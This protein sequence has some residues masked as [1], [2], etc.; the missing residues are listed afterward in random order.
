MLGANTSRRNNISLNHL[1]QLE[2][3][4]RRSLIYR[5]MS[6]SAVQGYC[7]LWYSHYSFYLHKNSIIGYDKKEGLEIG[8]ADGKYCIVAKFGV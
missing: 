2:P 5:V 6:K 3:Y 1:G 8:F 4:G 7:P